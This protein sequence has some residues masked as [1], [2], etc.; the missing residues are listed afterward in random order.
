MAT[1]DVLIPHFRDP[2]GLA[3]SLCSIATQNWTGNLRVLVLDDGSSEG[4]F[5]QVQKTVERFPRAISLLRNEENVGRPK[6]RNRLLAASDAPYIAWLDAGDTWHVDKLRIQ[7][8][9]LRRLEYT[10]CDIHRVWITCH[11]QWIVEGAKPRMRHQ[12]IE[13]DQLESLLIGDDLRA[14]LWTLLG[15]REAFQAAGLFDEQLLRLQDLDFFIRFVRAGG[16]IEVP[17]ARV[18]LCDY[19]K[20]DVGRDHVQ[21][22]KSAE[23]IFQKNR[24]IYEKY[25]QDFVNRALWK[26]ARL[27]ARFANHNNARGASIYYLLRGAMRVPRFIVQRIHHRIFA[28]FSK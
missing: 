1:L 24:S 12:K 10:G 7:F 27:S 9:H 11:Y 14:Y 6:A 26:N 16:N 22:S 15:R 17:P 18:P 2:A 25:G 3:K 5:S 8:E 4:V 13:G 19:Y 23:R 28:R 21:V 20:S